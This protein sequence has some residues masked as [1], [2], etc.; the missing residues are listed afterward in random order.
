MTH[1]ILLLDDGESLYNTYNTTFR[2]NGLELICLNALSEITEVLNKNAVDLVLVDTT[3]T[4]KN[5]LCQL[6]VEFSLPENQNTPFIFLGTDILD[7]DKFDF[8]LKIFLCLP[9][10]PELL[11]NTIQNVLSE[12]KRREQWNYQDKRNTDILSLTKLT[13]KSMSAER[14]LQSGE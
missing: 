13:N 4:P 7:S 6:V 10:N 2:K 12:K 9:I 3:Q 14:R 11:V 5:I 1:K 8:S